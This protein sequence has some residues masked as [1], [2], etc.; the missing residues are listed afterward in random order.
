MVT[1]MVVHYKDKKLSSWPFTDV[2]IVIFLDTIWERPIGT[3][4]IETVLEVPFLTILNFQMAWN[5]YI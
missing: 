1:I 4:Y 2:S 5:I 3:P